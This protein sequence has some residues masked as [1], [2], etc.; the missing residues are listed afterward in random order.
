M[1]TEINEKNSINS[2]LSKRFQTSEHDSESP[3]GAFGGFG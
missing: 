2:S 1:N 3:D